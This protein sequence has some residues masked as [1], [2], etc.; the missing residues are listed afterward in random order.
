LVLDISL[1]VDDFEVLELRC[2]WLTLTEEPRVGLPVLCAF[3][4]DESISILW[5]I[6]YE[7]QPTHNLQNEGRGVQASSPV[8]NCSNSNFS[9]TL[10]RSRQKII[11]KS[12]LSIFFKTLQRGGERRV[13]KKRE[14]GERLNTSTSKMDGKD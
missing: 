12:Y 6:H 14:K 8:N 11:I 5:R 13:R 2:R 4:V 1:N 10:C 3:P 9:S 7:R